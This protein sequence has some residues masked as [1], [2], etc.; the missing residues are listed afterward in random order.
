MTWSRE[1]TVED[2]LGELIERGYRFVHPRNEQ[3]EIITVVGVRAHGT[4]IDIVRLDAE[5]DVL[6]MRMPGD[7]QNILAPETI[8]W[9]RSGAMHTVVAD[10]LRLADDDFAPRAESETRGCW[11]PSGRAGRAKW[12]VATA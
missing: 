6:A 5:D 2:V 1:T 11:V 10:L 7:E 9:K 8:L 4:V 12:L 3:G